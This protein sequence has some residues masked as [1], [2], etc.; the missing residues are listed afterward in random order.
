MP[1]IVQEK[2]LQA[3][4]ILKELGIDLWLTFVRETSAAGDPV[5][6]LI[7]GRDLTWQSALIITQSGISIAIVGRLES[8][9]ASDIGAYQEVIPYDQGISQPLIEVLERLNPDQIAINYSQNDVLADGLTHGLYQV[10]S[11]YLAGSLYNERL[12]SAE[13]IIAALR[14]RKSSTEIKRMTTAI[15]TSQSIFRETFEHV[16]VGMSEI[17]VAEYMQSKV[18]GLGLTTAWERAHCPLVNTGP[19]S[20]AG[21]SAPTERE[22]APGHILHL[23]F[24]VKQDEYCADIQR[25]AYFLDS[26]ETQAPIPVQKGFETIVIA[27]QEAVQEMKPGKSGQE[28]DAVARRVVTQAGYPEFK[29]AT[30]HHLGR[31]AHDGAGI[32]GPDWERYGETVYYLLEP[33]HVYTVEPSLY[34]PD[35]GLVGIEEDVLV[36]DEGARFLSDPQTELILCK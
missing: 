21:H 36:T 27:I 34:V 24:G 28:I 32:I 9:T 30:G 25:V 23:D 31:L 10:L 20:A 18:D 15:E 29:H 35:F 14:G 7:Y 3:T 26:G 1:T 17:Q 6:P 16:H 8:Q 22:I 2:V 12:V 19:A 5:L 13:S 33:G 11:R 4:D